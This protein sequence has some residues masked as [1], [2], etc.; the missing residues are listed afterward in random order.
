MLFLNSWRVSSHIVRYDT[1]PPPILVKNS[2]DMHS[3]EA[4][5]ESPLIEYECEWAFRIRAQVS[6]FDFL[7]I[8]GRQTNVFHN[9]EIVKKY[10]LS[11]FRRIMVFV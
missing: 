6:I 9:T 2:I 11:L 4:Q 3:R 10:N 1:N 8:L 7:N 5:I